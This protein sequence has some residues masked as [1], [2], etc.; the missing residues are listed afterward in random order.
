M[1]DKVMIQIGTNNGADE[2]NCLVKSLNPNM[3]ILVEPNIKLNG[4]IIKNYEGIKNFYLENVA[5]T[6]VSKGLVKLVIPKNHYDK[7]GIRIGKNNYVD[8]HYSLLP[9]DDWGNDFNEVESPSMTFTELCDK[10]GIVNIHYLQIDTEGYDA[11]IIKSINFKHLNIDIIKYEDWSFPIDCFSRHG[12]KAK[13]YGI[14]GMVEVDYL[15]RGLGY[16]I[17]KEKSDYIAIKE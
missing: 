5:I 10:Y 8:C 16:T 17:T 14:N 7:N 15:L 9:M 2:F 1:K 3:V 6:E 4:E 12:D 13:H 11:E